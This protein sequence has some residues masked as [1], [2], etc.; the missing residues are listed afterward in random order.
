MKN[1]E[2]CILSEESNGTLS[3]WMEEILPAPE[4]K[5]RASGETQVRGRWE[6]MDEL[7][8]L[9]ACDVAFP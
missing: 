8:N 7:P 1:G 2:M 4:P 3:E 6:N 5:E 9:P